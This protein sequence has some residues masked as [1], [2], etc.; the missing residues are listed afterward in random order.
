MSIAKG[1]KE[2]L[3]TTSYLEYKN[4]GPGA[5]T[6]KRIEWSRQLTDKEAK[7]VT[8]DEVMRLQ[9]SAWDIAL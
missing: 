8:I 2:N 9:E 5:N 6:D 7:E 3:K 1:N 4:Y